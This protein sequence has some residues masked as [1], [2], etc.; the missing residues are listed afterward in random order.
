MSTVGDYFQSALIRGLDEGIGRDGLVQSLH[1]TP[2]DG[3]LE[4]MTGS[5]GDTGPVGDPARPFQWEGEIADQAVL[6]ALAA[7]LDTAHAGKAWRVRGTDTLVYWNGT[8][9]DTF[10]D[11][12]GAAGPEGVACTVSVGTVDTG[13]VG[14]DLQVTV[15]GTPPNLTMNL[16]VPRGVKGRKGDQGSPG[17]IRKAPDYADG[18]HLDG[19]VPVWSKAV[20]KWVP[21]AYP[22]LR[23]PW[24]IVGGQAWDGGPG[25]ADSMY[26]TS[27]SP[28]IVARLNI[29]PQDCDWRPV[30]T[31]GVIAQTVEDSQTFDTRVDAEV[32]L[33]SDS[34]QIVALGP[35]MGSGIAY[36]CGFQP[37][38]GA[39]VTPD[40]SVGV[41]RAG[42][43]AVLNVVLRIITGKSNYN[44]IMD[45]AQVV[46]W[47][48]PVAPAPI[49]GAL[50]FNGME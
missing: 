39:R 12:F 5:L 25:F 15:T 28:N 10:A 16:T 3:S 1:G 7:K 26:N 40:S 23:G 41:V 32:R 19:A 49:S 4:L 18:P 24:S 13:P 11:A 2:R 30:V 45:R 48:R 8:S 34:G 17:P 36:H 46:C 37:F 21:R 33:G 14:S 43:P 44:Y 42:Q 35:G 31:G 47:V 50:R 9:F 29:P 27:A 22:G 38:Y 20:G 6:S